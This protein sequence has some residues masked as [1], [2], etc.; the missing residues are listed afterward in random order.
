MMRWLNEHTGHAIL[1]VN[2]SAWQS[3]CFTAM[4]HC[5][6]IAHLKYVRFLNIHTMGTCWPLVVKNAHRLGVKPSDLT[7]DIFTAVS[8]SC[9]ATCSKHTLLLPQLT[10]AKDMDPSEFSS[11]L[12]NQ[13]CRPSNIQ[14]GDDDQKRSLS[15]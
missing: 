2:M 4:Q 15:I 3:R 9:P 1:P 7:A 14:H 11:G 5:R 12:C 6:L 10:P 8:A 13:N